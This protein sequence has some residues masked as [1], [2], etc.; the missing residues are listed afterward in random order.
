MNKEELEQKIKSLLAK[1]ADYSN[2]T[3]QLEMKS[4]S[5]DVRELQESIVILSH[6]N[7]TEIAEA[8]TIE[9]PREDVAE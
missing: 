7:S 1:M 9:E 6:L 2:I 4:L 5:E 8:T 3:K